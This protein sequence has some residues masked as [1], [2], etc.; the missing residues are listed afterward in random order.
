MSWRSALAAY[1]VINASCF[2]AVYTSGP[3]EK[4]AL[5]ISKVPHYRVTRAQFISDEVARSRVMS[6]VSGLCT[7]G[8]VSEY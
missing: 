4:C 6:A 3:D 7:L 5:V 1:Y 8:M 2:Y